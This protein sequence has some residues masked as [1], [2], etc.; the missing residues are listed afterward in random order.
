MSEGTV[1]LLDRLPP[2]LLDQLCDLYE[3]EWWTRGRSRESV[4]RAIAGSTE[5]V[6]AVRGDRLVGFA[7]ALSD[8]AYRAIVFDVIVVPELRGS[9]LGRRVMDAILAAPAVAASNR[10]ELICLPEM[11]PFYERW[12]FEPAQPG[13]LRMIRGG[14]ISAEEA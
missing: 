1:E 12:G 7:R 10:V 9:G 6:A 4:E 14:E 5:I 2:E 11:A 3:A 8:T 13:V